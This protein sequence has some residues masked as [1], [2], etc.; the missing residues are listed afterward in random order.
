MHG[1]SRR[2][3]CLYQRQWWNNRR[4]SNVRHGRQTQETTAPYMKSKQQRQR[5][6]ERRIRRE[7]K[8][9]CAIMEASRK[10]ASNTP[11]AL[12]NSTV[13]VS[14]MAKQSLPKSNSEIKICS[15]DGC[16]KPVKP[17]RQ[18][19]SMHGA[20]LE[21]HGDVNTNL[22][23]EES[24]K[25]RF[26]RR[27]AI[28]NPGECW[29][30]TGHLLST[31]YGKAVFRGKRHAASRLA[32]WFAKG[33]PRL[34]VL[35]T[36]D[37]PVCCNPNH[38]YEGTPQQNIRDMVS[39]DRQARGERH[40]SSKYSEAQIREVIRL[41]PSGLNAPQIEAITG[42]SFNTVKQVRSGKVWKHLPREVV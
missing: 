37:N 33:E 39:R 22:Y 31:G 10:G 20:R 27:V 21:R 35:H 40:G 13:E 14:N 30:W 2:E 18:L 32:Y 15:V 34:W 3:I 8:Q 19:C 17:R 5:I 6:E 16:Q 9:D 1:T 12:T 24:F 42:V 36:C 29:P 11:P 23:S 41:I 25:E 4:S 38:L 28:G 26:W 7:D